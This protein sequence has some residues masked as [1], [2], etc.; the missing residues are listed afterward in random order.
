MQKSFVG[1]GARKYASIRDSSILQDH[2]EANVCEP[3]ETGSYIKYKQGPNLSFEARISDNPNF[4][5]A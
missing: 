5:I 2:P 4:R 1:I 3:K